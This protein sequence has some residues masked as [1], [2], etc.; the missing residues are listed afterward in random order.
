VIFDEYIQNYAAFHPIYWAGG[1]PWAIYQKVL[2]PLCHLHIQPNLN[3][4]EIE[5]LL[6]ES[7]ARFIL[8]TYDFDGAESQWWWIIAEKP[9]SLESLKPKARY[10]VRHGLRKCDVRRISGRVLAKTGYSCYHSAMQRHTQSVPLPELSFRE[11]MPRH[12]QNEA[13][14]LWGV[15][16]KG[17]LVGYA[18]YKVI[19]D[20]VYEGD[21]I[22]NP[23]FFKF[24][25]TYALVHTT[26]NHYLNERDCSYLVSGWR[27]LRH[28]TNFQNFTVKEFGRRKAYCRLRVE[29]SSLY[30]ILR[31]IN[32]YLNPLL[33]RIALPKKMKHERTALYRLEKIRREENYQ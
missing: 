18:I 13:L 9:Y 33:A 29:Y 7:K 30:G 4:E 14:E 12:D 22:L 2:R 8:W 20:I 17:L 21:V 1:I 25:S 16:S 24:H 26:A 32:Y 10:N 19:D 5:A 23:H 15:F 27:S 11:R 3:Q 28:E 6:R 31:N